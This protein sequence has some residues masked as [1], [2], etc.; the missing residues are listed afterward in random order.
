VNI[1]LIQLRR[2]GDLILTTPAIAAVRARFP[3]AQLSLVVSSGARELLPAIRG[4]N[5]TFVAQ[6]KITDAASFFGVARRRFDY[7]LDF[8]RNDRSAFLALLSKAGKRI[9]AD[10]PRKRGQLQSLSYNTL[11]PLDV[12]IMHTVD[13]HL[14]LLEPLGI[15]A[16]AREVQLDLPTAAAK[17]ADEVLRSAGVAREFVVLHPGSARIEKFWEA[18]R[19]GAIIDFAAQRE[20][21][22]V[23]T[24]GT[25]ALEQDH[26][27]RIKRTTRQ[28]LVDLSGKID[29]LSLAAVIK[30]ARLLVTVDSAPVHLAAAMRTPQVALF[31]PTN[32]FHW[33]PRGAPA[34]VLQG[35][36]AY[37]PAE[38][39]P[40]QKP[41]ATNLISTQQLIDAMEALLA[42]PRVASV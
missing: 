15:R 12:G 34:I 29:L 27:G 22:C 38:F 6:G 1:L 32:P 20:L 30:R 35:G 4:V 16:A 13:Y 37:P 18:E 23:L 11:V 42:A 21:S 40:K 7:C 25:S 9:T 26:I 28:P 17:R 31:G 24:G 10:Y 14:G 33:H 8:T 19:W 41:A 39:T 36:H 2:I 3:E 5:P